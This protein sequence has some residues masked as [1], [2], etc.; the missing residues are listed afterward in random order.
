MRTVAPS[1]SNICEASGYIAPVR[2]PAML[3]GER[4]ELRA[5][6]EVILAGGAFNT[7]QLL[8]LCGIGPQQELQRH[9]IEV[10]VDLPGVGKNLQDRYEAAVVNRMTF[11]RVGAVSRGEI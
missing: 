10:K 9:G 8:M 6:R 7:P 4:L 1:G 11:D 2:D 3:R 5:S